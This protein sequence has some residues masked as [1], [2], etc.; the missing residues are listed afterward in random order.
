MKLKSRL[1]E[2]FRP[3]ANKAV[4][5]WVHRNNPDSYHKRLQ[6]GDCPLCL[7]PLE[8]MREKLAE[9]LNVEELREKVAAMMED[10]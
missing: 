10:E 2:S 1:A 4:D 7:S 3:A 5:E 9:S 6:G 8:E